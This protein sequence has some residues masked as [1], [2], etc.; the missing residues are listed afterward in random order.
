MGK[1]FKYYKKWSSKDI[2]NY[3]IELRQACKKDMYEA[4][5]ILAGAI[6]EI[7]KHL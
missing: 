1:T 7:N 3:L 6:L 2:R 5:S 4:K